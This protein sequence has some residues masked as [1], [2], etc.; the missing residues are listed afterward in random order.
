MI[1]ARILLKVTPE[2]L[3]MYSIDWH[4]PW[5][6]GGDHTKDDLY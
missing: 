2:Y 6:T 5:Q 1:H 3:D 4:E